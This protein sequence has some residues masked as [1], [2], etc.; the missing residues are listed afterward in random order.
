[1]HFKKIGISVFMLICFFGCKKEVSQADIIPL[2]LSIKSQ[3]D[4]LQFKMNKLQKTT[5]SILN[6]VSANSAKLSS[7]SSKIDSIKLELT[8]VLNKINELNNSLNLTDASVENILQQIELL[9]IKCASLYKL[10]NDLLKINSGEIKIK[11][12]IIEN[13]SSPFIVGGS[14]ESTLNDSIIEKGVI[15]GYSTGFKINIG[16][17]S[18]F[19]HIV[20]LNSNI[21]LVNLHMGGWSTPS[22]SKNIY[23]KSFPGNGSFSLN[24]AGSFGNTTY[25]V[26]A[27]AKTVDSI[28]Y[29]DELL[30][31]SPN[32][33]RDS[34]RLDISNVYWSSNYNLFDLLT[35]EIIYPDANG[36]Y[37]FWYSSNE[38]ITVNSISKTAAQLQNFLFYK[39]KTKENC[40]RW[41]DLRSG[42]V[43]PIN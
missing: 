31:I 2:L 10:I 38:S 18:N 43:S 39:F 32:Y 37:N 41:C 23:I 6:I 20:A 36:M 11:T 21:A 13:I 35:D 12:L 26:K 30:L 40:Q 1:M 33:G 24:V 4:S 15:I 22:K 14:V 28:Y 9:K 19:N 25:Y 5:D 34:R 17:S 42:R 8:V 16:D 7:L 29:G 27:Y 3:N